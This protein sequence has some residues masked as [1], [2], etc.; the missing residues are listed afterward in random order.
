MVVE[1]HVQYTLTNYGANLLQL[2][3]P[4]PNTRRC[5]QICI[6]IGPL[7]RSVLIIFYWH[8]T[9]WTNHEK[10]Y[11]F[12]AKKTRGPIKKC[13]LVPRNFWW[14]MQSIT[15][16]LLVKKKLK[17]NPCD[18]RQLLLGEHSNGIGFPMRA[19]Y[20]GS[21][22]SSIEKCGKNPPEKYD[23]FFFID[24]CCSYTEAK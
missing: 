24:F 18:W 22:S 11:K 19:H 13:S 20:C 21:L 4:L 8:Q 2:Q 23:D 3:H 5:M 10:V 1:F 6:P 12:R 16:S 7:F 17:A 15:W 9:W 14:K